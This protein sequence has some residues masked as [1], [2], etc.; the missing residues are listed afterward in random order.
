[1]SGSREELRNCMVSTA[2][3]STILLL[4]TRQINALI[5]ANFA[6]RLPAFKNHKATTRM[7]ASDDMG[8]NELQCLD[9][10]QIAA[11]AERDLI[12][13]EETHIMSVCQI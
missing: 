6:E 1:M 4:T 13:I 12:E 9:D 11:S 2:L 7:P 10:Q 5:R 3:T 8:C